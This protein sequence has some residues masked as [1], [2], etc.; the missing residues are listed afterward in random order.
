MS[1][2]GLGTHKLKGSKVSGTPLYM[3]P[4]SEINE[5][6]E[7]FGNDIWAL[8]VTLIVLLTGKTPEFTNQKI[9]K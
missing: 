6:D 7:S 3:P 2:F 5:G 4:P 8:G 9:D 1:D